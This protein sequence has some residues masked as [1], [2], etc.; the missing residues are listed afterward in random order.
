M[1]LTK[2][3]SFLIAGVFLGAV[4]VVMLSPMSPLTRKAAVTG[5]WEGTT[6]SPAQP[7]VPYYGRGGLYHPPVCGEGRT[8]LL[9]HG[10][11]WIADPPSELTG[12]GVADA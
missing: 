10:W 9:R 6:W 5:G 11:G 2:E 8:G 12:P 7:R 1:T 4:A 3:Q